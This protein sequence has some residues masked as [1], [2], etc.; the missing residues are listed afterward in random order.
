MDI[1]IASNEQSRTV[2]WSVCSGNCFQRQKE[3]EGDHF[4]LIFLEGEKKKEKNQYSYTYL[5]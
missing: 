1:L 3:K 2:L 5:N 4:N